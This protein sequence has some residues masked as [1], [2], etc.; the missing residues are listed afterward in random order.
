MRGN[1]HHAHPG[2]LA[3]HLRQHIETIVLTQA[4]IEKTQVEYLALQQRLGLTCI[5]R[6]TDLIALIL[7]AIAKSP[8]YRPFIVDQQNASALHGSCF[9]IRGSIDV[10]MELVRFC[11]CKLQ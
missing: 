9:H 6:G 8:Q 7:Q 10:C 1:Y 5:G 11:S 2:R 4:Q 3:T